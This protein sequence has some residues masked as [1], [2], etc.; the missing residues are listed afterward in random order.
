MNPIPPSPPSR[1]EP[2]QPRS[3]AAYL[4][5]FDDRMRIPLI[6]SAVLPLIIVPESAGWVGTERR[7]HSQPYR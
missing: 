3:D 2:G 6:V 5:T 7:R 4:A 1:V